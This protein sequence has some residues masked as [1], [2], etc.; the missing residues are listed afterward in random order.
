MGELDPVSWDATLPES[1]TEVWIEYATGYMAKPGCA[2]DVV[3][4]AVPSDVV[5]PVMPGCGDNPLSE[6]AE[7][8]R[9]WVEGIIR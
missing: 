5:L 3:S 7:R 4:I 9:Q 1:L 2:E 6:F 8:T